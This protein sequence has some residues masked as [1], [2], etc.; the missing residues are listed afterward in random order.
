MIGFMRVFANCIKEE[1]PFVLSVS[2]V[3]SLSVVQMEVSCHFLMETIRD[4]KIERQLS[5]KYA[6]VLVSVCSV[7]GL[8]TR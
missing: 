4:L 5:I 8:I 3:G 7:K 2:H 6:N 1:W